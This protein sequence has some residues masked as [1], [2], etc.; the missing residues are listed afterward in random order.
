MTLRKDAFLTAGYTN[1]K[2]AAGEKTG[3]FPVHERSEVGRTFCK[4][5]TIVYTMIILVVH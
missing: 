4:I 1:W 5:L 2:D 3:G